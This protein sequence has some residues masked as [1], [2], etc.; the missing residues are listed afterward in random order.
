MERKRRTPH[1][2]QV[3]ALIR[4]HKAMWAITTDQA[5]FLLTSRCFYCGDEPPTPLP[6]TITRKDVGLDYVFSNCVA[7]CSWCAIAKGIR[8][9]QEFLAKVKQIAALQQLGE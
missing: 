5:R 1:G 7:T 3:E 6:G 2:W 4:A 8:C 9:E